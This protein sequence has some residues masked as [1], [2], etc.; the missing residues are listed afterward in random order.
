MV[1]SEL[2]GHERG[3]FTG[4]Y[5]SNAGKF[6]LANKGILFMDEISE[7]PV[8]L[9]G[10]LLRVLENR[11]IVRIGGKKNISVDVMILA[12]TNRELEVEIKN[13][14]FR[15]D[16]YF[17]LNM[18]KIELPPLRDRRE[19]IPLLTDFFLKKINLKLGKKL[20][21]SED[22]LELL[23]EYYYPGN[24]RELKNIIFNAALFCTD[25]II[26]QKYLRM[27]MSPMHVSDKNGGN[28]GN[29]GGQYT[30]EMIE[31]RLKFHGGNITETAQ[32]L[33]YTREGLSRKLKRMNI[34]RENFQ[35]DSE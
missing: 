3:S 14:K 10:K 19:D 27:C 8:H 32:E 16:I 22:A 21:F 20:K 23:R 9:Q 1:D 4:A 15:E 13:G 35:V 12:A 25:K 17:R 28:S 6:E 34:D 30:K 2:F 11:E 26:A 31:D 5:S 29:K 18:V 33:G 7:M 24:V